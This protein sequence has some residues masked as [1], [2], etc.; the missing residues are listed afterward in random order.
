MAGLLLVLFAGHLLLL[1]RD[2]TREHR[3]L[4]AATAETAAN[5][6]RATVSV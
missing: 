6:P 2:E 4:E 1:A 5:E 3:E